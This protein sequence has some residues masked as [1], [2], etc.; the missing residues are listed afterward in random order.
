[1]Y[2]YLFIL[3][4]VSISYLG[5]KLVLNARVVITEMNEARTILSQ[6]HTDPQFGE[7]SGKWQNK[8]VG[9]EAGGVVE[10]N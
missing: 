1:M 2:L 10:I 5:D 7:H 9:W 3:Y 6:Y 4:L 8:L